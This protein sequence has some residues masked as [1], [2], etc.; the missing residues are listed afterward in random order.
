VHKIGVRFEQPVGFPV[1][2]NLVDDGLGRRRSR[3]VCED[4]CIRHGGFGHHLDPAGSE[5]LAQVLPFR[6]IDQVPIRMPSA[7]LGG[8]GIAHSKR[9]VPAG[10][11]D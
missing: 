3:M 10:S 5:E 2:T 4:A 1:L 8:V 11:S 6:G 9:K 7:S